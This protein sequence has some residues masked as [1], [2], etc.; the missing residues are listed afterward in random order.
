M[1]TGVTEWTLVQDEEGNWCYPED[2][3]YVRHNDGLWY[4]P[5]D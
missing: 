3:G 2:A 1:A 5:C 4:P